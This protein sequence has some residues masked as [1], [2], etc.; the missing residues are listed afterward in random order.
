MDVFFALS[1]PTRRDI[2]EILAQQGQMASSEIA[3]RF[4][5]T[6]SAVSQ[7]LKV[8]REAKL[9]RMEKKAQKRLYAVDTATLMQLEQWTREL[10][11]TWDERFNRLDQ[12]LSN[13]E[14]HHGRR[15]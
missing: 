7:H 12:L 11:G 13:K 9:V 15:K 8:L 14:A 5:S 10:Q 2:L 6:P 1:E 3:K 4:R